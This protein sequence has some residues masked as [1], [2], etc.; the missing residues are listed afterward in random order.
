LSILREFFK[1]QVLRGKL[2]GDPTLPI[3]RAKKRA[4]LR[5]TFTDEQRIQIVGAQ[6]ELRDRIALRLLLDYGIRKGSLQAIQFK[7]FDHLR[8]RLVVF[9]KGGKIRDLP[10]PHPAFWDDLGRL[11]VDLQAEP[12][13]YLLPRQ[14]AIPAPHKKDI[15]W[16]GMRM[17]M[18][19]GQP[20]GATACTTGGTAVSPVPA[21]SPGDNQR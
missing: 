3:E 1:F 9:A 5:T 11:I 20:M 7:H 6:T 4:V 19:P 12:G 10:I 14:K 17:H 16:A 2:H 18:F 8:K 21:L 15:P 13:H